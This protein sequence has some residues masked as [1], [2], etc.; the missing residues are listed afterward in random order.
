MSQIDTCYGRRGLLLTVR[1]S[2]AWWGFNDDA[3]S[4]IVNDDNCFWDIDTSGQANSD[5]GTGR[6][7]R[8]DEDRRYL[9]GRWLGFDYALEY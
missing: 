2:A 7:H 4:A 9:S 8:T 6:T 3:S 1:R 5:G